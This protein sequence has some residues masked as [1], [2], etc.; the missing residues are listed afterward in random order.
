MWL[1][2]VE[3]AATSAA[4][5]AQCATDVYGLAI[6][7]YWWPLSGAEEV[8][9]TAILMLPETISR[10]ASG[11]NPV[12]VCTRR[13]RHLKLLGLHY[14]HRPCEP[15]TIDRQPNR[16]DAVQECI[17]CMVWPPAFWWAGCR[18]DNY[19]T[20]ALVCHKCSN[21]LR[22]LHKGVPNVRGAG[23]IVLPCFMCRKESRLCTTSN[24]GKMQQ[25]EVRDLQLV[26]GV[27]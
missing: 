11:Y 4:L 23:D 1:W 20:R 6:A 8:D 9:T 10:L 21:E 18:H 16:S 2:L 12:G 22:R 7:C 19:G 15:H 26:L 14:P 17:I 24:V 25:Q 13:L 3:V 27:R 5:R